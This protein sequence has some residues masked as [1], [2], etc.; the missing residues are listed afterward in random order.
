[1]LP[2]NWSTPDYV[3][4]NWRE[5]SCAEVRSKVNGRQTKCIHLEVRQ[6]SHNSETHHHS[7][8]LDNF[9]N[10]IRTVTTF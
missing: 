3:S 5:L 7:S 4:Q 6:D 2:I 10:R 8:N 9:G 1:M